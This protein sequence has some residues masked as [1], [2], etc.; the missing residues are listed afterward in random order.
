MWK[1]F[2]SLAITVTAVYIP[3]PATADITSFPDCRGDECY[4]SKLN[5]TVESLETGLGTLHKIETV[6]RT[7]RVGTQPPNTWGSPKTS[8]VHCS[9]TRPAVIGQISYDPQM[10]YVNLVNLRGLPDRATA[11]SHALYWLVCHNI[12]YVYESQAPLARQLGYLP[13]I[14]EDQI[15]FSIRDFGNINAISSAVLSTPILGTWVVPPLEFDAVC[16]KFDA[17]GVLSFIGGFNFYNPATWTYNHSNSELQITLNGNDDIGIANS[18]G[19]YSGSPI[20]VNSQNRTLTYRVPPDSRLLFSGYFFE[21]NIVCP[22][23]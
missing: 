1:Q 16:M 2:L 23:P 21:K 9:T 13:N 4:E 17:N 7:W 18:P 3:K 12:D 15:Q 14:Q 6:S 22:Y 19:S 10:A 11:P 8:Y 5:R 20:R